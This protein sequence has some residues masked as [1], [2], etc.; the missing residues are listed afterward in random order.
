MFQ[1]TSEVRHPSS[2]SRECS[3]HQAGQA[4][5]GQALLDAAEE[6]HPSHGHRPS[7]TCLHPRVQCRSR[8]SAVRTC[9]HC[10]AWPEFASLASW[11]LTMSRFRMRHCQSKGMIS[12]RKILGNAT[13]VIL[14]LF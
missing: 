9:C 10:D 2:L 13:V 6:T 4:S 11:L 5:F 12:S 8:A 3:G 14:L 1:H 7:E